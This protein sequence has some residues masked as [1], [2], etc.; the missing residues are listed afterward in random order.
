MTSGIGPSPCCVDAQP[1]GLN[2]DVFG[3][4]FFK[5]QLERN[6]DVSARKMVIFGM[7]NGRIMEIPIYSSITS[8]IVLGK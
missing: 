6:G 3:A 2:R 7:K 5:G 1:A 4:S 8:I